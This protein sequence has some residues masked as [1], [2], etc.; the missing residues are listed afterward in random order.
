MEDKSAMLLTGYPDIKYRKTKKVLVFQE[1]MLFQ[2][3]YVHYKT[4][5]ILRVLECWLQGVLGS[6]SIHGICFISGQ[7]ADGSFYYNNKCLIAIIL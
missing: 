7:G 5:L 6:N 2:K 1:Y 4:Y 3:F